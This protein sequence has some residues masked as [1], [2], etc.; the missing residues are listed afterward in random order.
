MSA[1]C[2]AAQINVFE[3]M[4]LFLLHHSIVLYRISGFPVLVIFSGKALRIG[5]NFRAY[6]VKVKVAKEISSNPY[7][8]PS[9]HWVLYLSRPSPGR[10]RL[11][12]L[13]VVC[14]GYKL[15]L[16]DPESERM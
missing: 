1:I 9:S 6:V 3:W 15:A 14:L 10:T 2:F 11:L 12:N 16:K 4:Y 13:T 8:N 7:S 5:E